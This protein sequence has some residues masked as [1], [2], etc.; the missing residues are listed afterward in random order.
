MTKLANWVLLSSWSLWSDFVN[1]ISLIMRRMWNR[2]KLM[3]IYAAT[4]MASVL[5]IHR[6]RGGVNRGVLLPIFSNGQ[7]SGGNAEKP[8]TTGGQDY[9]SF[10]YIL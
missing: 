1:V 3:Q 10:E 7:L 8:T 5:H 9:L 4:L 2:G 6:R